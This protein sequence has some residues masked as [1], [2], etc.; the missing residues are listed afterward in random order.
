MSFTEIDADLNSG[1]AV[2]SMMMTDS[3][4]N[5]GDYIIYYN[6]TTYDN[7]SAAW[8]GGG[9]YFLHGVGFDSSAGADAG[10][11]LISLLTLS[12]PDVPEIIQVIVLSPIFAC[13]CYLIWFIVKETLPFV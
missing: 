6:T 8:D 5:A 12:V 3:G 11:L 10:S 1:S 7:A 4:K 2:Y 9:L 13:V